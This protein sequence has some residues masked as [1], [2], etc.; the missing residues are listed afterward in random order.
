MTTPCR[1]AK[2]RTPSTLLDLPSLAGTATPGAQQVQG[3]AI[4]QMPEWARRLSRRLLFASRVSRI[5]SMS[6]IG[7]RDEEECSNVEPQQTNVESVLPQ[8]TEI[9]VPHV[10]AELIEQVN[11]PSCKA[12]TF[13]ML[14]L[15]W[16]VTVVG[17]CVGVVVWTKNSVQAEPLPVNGIQAIPSDFKGQCGLLGRMAFNVRLQC[18][19]QDVITSVTGDDL[20]I[21]E[22]LTGIVFKDITPFPFSCEP[23]NLALWNLITN[24]D[25]VLFEYQVFWQRYVLTVL[26]FE[27]TGD[28]WI[29]QKNNWLDYGR[30]CDWHGVHCNKYGTVIGIKQSRN[31]LKGTIPSELALLHTLQVISLECKDDDDF[32]GSIPSELSNLPFLAELH[33]QNC[34]LNGTIPSDLWNHPKLTVLSLEFNKL[35]GSISA[36]IGKSKLEKLNVNKNFMTGTIPVTFGMLENTLT[37]M[38]ISGNKF[39][40][41]IPSELARLSKLSDLTLGENKLAHQ[42]V[43][44]WL[45]SLTDLVVLYLGS[46]KLTG[47]IPSSIANLSKLQ[48]FQADYNN[49]SGT[50]PTQIGALTS[51]TNLLFGSNRFVGSLPSELGL[52]ANVIQLS[53]SNNAISGTFPSS[54]SHLEFASG[55]FFETNQLTGEMAPQICALTNGVLEVLLIDC[56][57]VICPC[58]AC[59]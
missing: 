40:G 7:E 50:I 25:D 2:H 12:W 49:F 53:V 20:A 6:V 17:V 29:E 48:D 32:G 35:T 15:L 28:E 4:G 56:H 44:D 23:A 41:W 19:C 16:A 10:D 8:L 3:R 30:E 54:L 14:N 27:W 42:E 55:L 13:V 9:I 36:D 11:K 43:P 57:E 37:E 47:K 52:L 33:L 26:Y 46:L 59:V 1:L 5:S 58:C 18:D 39:T 31:G 22:K 34:K 51:L 21:Y 24:K 45:W 38:I